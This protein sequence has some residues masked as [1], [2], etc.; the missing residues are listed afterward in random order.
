MPSAIHGGDEFMDLP[1]APS[2]TENG[3]TQVH[4]YISQHRTIVEEDGEKDGGL[5]AFLQKNFSE[6]RPLK[7]RKTPF[8][9]T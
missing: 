6:L 3:G 8:L 5:G 7:R 4:Y 9:G 2:S 1:E